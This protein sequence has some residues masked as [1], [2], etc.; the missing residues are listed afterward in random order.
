MPPGGPSGS[1]SSPATGGGAA[2]KVPGARAGQRTSTTSARGEKAATGT[3]RATSGRR[4]RTA[5]PAVP[6]GETPTRPVRSR[7]PTRRGTGD[8]LRAAAEVTVAAFRS[9][10]LLVP[11][12]AALVEL[13]LVLAAKID[14][15]GADAPAA[16]VKEYREALAMLYATVGG[17]S[18]DEFTALLADLSAAVGDSSSA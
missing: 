18:P 1:S 4:A 17:R 2:S 9:Q 15:A 5:T 10:D 6:D 3:T 8:S 7:K 11:E 13:V 16:L 12:D 14:T